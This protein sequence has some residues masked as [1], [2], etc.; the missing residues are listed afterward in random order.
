M[1]IFTFLFP[2]VELGVSCGWHLMVL[3]VHL[4][5]HPFKQ[6][7]TLVKHS[8]EYHNSHFVFNLQYLHWAL[9][10]LDVSVPRIFANLA[11]TK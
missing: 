7:K 2:D 1:T 9:N 5:I 6:K 8:K 10:A 3:N 11:E 4:A